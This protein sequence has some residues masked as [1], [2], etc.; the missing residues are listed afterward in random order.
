M[1]S[2]KQA[3]KSRQKWPESQC[4]TVPKS[5][6]LDKKTWPYPF[7]V[8]KLGRNLKRTKYITTTFLTCTILSRSMK[9]R[10]EVAAYL[11]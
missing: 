2:Y 1:D 10:P 7:P 5:F 11:M 4:D 8:F 9:S 6:F 3:K